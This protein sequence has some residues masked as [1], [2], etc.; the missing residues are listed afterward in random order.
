MPPQLTGFL[1]RFGAGLK[2]FTTGQRTVAVIGAALLVVG[3][4]AQRGYQANAQV[5][6]RARESYLAA[7]E[8]GRS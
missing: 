4:I 3:I 5:V 2:G 6:D 8:I 7:L 1:Q